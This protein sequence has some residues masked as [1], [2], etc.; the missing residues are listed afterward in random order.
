MINVPVKPQKRF[1]FRRPGQLNNQTANNGF[2]GSGQTSEPSQYDTAVQEADLFQE[3]TYQ[4]GINGP[5]QDDFER[6]ANVD[7][8]DESECNEFFVNNAQQFEESSYR[9]DKEIDRGDFGDTAVHE[10]DNGLNLHDTTINGR[11]YVH[12]HSHV[13]TAEEVTVFS[14]PLSTSP[15]G[16]LIHE[17]NISLGAF[18]ADWI[19]L[20]VLMSIC[21]P[22][23]ILFAANG[24]PLVLILLIWPC[25][26][27]GRILWASRSTHYRIYQQQIEIRTGVLDK[28][29]ERIWIWR[30]REVKFQAKFWERITGAPRVIL[31]V[32]MPDL[33]NGTINREITIRALR[34]TRRDRRRGIKKLSTNKFMDLLADEL[35]T[36]A[37]E[38]RR[39]IKNFL[40]D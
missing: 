34:G 8:H 1:F 28:N 23:S 38:Q 37:Q 19:W 29:I 20:T 33:Q 22:V 13:N 10:H 16:A 12:G 5:L 4:E 11:G 26:K 39:S 24:Q 36:A 7:Q 17:S 14:A 21:M 9:Y 3:S 15:K 32:A 27:T 6:C 18:S 30:I 40:T 31:I 2:F 25:W 35:T